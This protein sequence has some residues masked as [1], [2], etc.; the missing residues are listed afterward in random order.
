[1][2]SASSS[3][4]VIHSFS[5]ARTSISGCAQVA[6]TA[7]TSGCGPGLVVAQVRRLVARRTSSTSASDSD[8]STGQPG[9]VERRRPSRAAAAVPRRGPFGQ[10]VEIHAL[11]REDV[12]LVAEDVV[13]PPQL[14]VEEARR[15]GDREDVAR[16]EFLDVAQGPVELPVPLLLAER[17]LGPLAA[18]RRPS[19]TRSRRRTAA[20]ARAPARARETASGRPGARRS[21][22]AAVA[23]RRTPT[24]TSRRSGRR[25]ARSATGS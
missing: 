9:L 14:L 25:S 11:V 6:L 15:P 7:S 1:M 8:A 4:G 18:A 20:G 2:W 19:G 16:A 3:S 17:L 23:R 13:E 12:R 5:S 21:G 24:A 22:S 10:P